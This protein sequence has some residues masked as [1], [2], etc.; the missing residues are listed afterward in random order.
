MLEPLIIDPPKSADSAVIWLHGLGANKYDFESEANLLQTHVLPHTRFILP[1][2]PTQPVTLNAGMAMPSWY[3]IIDLSSPRQCNLEQL[4]DS[5]QKV[6]ALIEEQKKQG[7]AS[8]RIILIGFSQG[9]AVV[10]HTAYLA[11]SDNVG[12]VVAMST[13]AATFT[14]NTLLDE[15][16]KTIPSLHLHGTQDPVVLPELGKAAY[17]FLLNQGVS[18]SWHDYPMQHSV[19]EEEVTDLAHW[20]V[21]HL[22]A[23]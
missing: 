11:Y 19:C 9:G 20:L 12:G 21:Q 5:A 18:A 13:Y 17:T 14:A 7:I 15:A 8:N 6:I 23:K 22:P 3:D 16:K 4:A 10:L 1:Q 2:A